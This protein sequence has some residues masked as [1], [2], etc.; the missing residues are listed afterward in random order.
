[1]FGGVNKVQNSNCLGFD[2]FPGV[3]TRGTHVTSTQLEGTDC[4][5][6]KSNPHGNYFG[7]RDLVRVCI[8]LRFMA[9]Q[10][11]ALGQRL[12]TT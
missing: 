3:S 7:V 8:V 2:F 6:Y 5:H 10:G 11:W 4:I 9:A 12:R 1:M